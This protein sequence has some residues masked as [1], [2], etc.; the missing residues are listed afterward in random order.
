MTT[1]NTREVHI[2][3]VG[4]GAKAAALAAR[5]SVLRDL[6]HADIRITVF[7]REK[8]GA[9]WTGENGYTDGVQA[10]CTP[11][12]RD[13]GFPYKS[14][15]GPA[16]DQSI[17]SEYSWGR[18][19]LERAGGNRNA[20]KNWVDRGRMP[21]AHREYARY[22]DWA[23]QKSSAKVVRQEV[24]RLDLAPGRKWYVTSAETPRSRPKTY[25]QM[26]DGVVVTGPGPA[27]RV[28]MVDIPPHLASRVFDGQSFWSNL[29]KVKEILRHEKEPEIVVIGGGGTG[30]AILAWLT[31]NGYSDVATKLIANKATLFSRG[32]SVFENNLFGDDEKWG[33][34]SPKNR[35]DFFERLNRGVV[36]NAVMEDL[37]NATNLE[38]IDGRAREITAVSKRRRISELTVRVQAWNPA[39]D[40][41]ARASLVVD[42]SGFDRWWFLPLIEHIPDV[43]KLSSNQREKL[44]SKIQP[45]LTLRWRLPPLHA[46][47]LAAA[48]GPGYGNLMALGAMSDSILKFYIPRVTIEEPA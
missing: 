12:E 35:E 41:S 30:A 2:A 22:L 26:F 16:V 6:G 10:L 27:R 15:R 11:V 13:L 39:L 38:L 5:A 4:G 45:D 40:F 33:A 21:P 47:N 17:Y 20:F 42:A 28:D 3:I 43:A 9:H 31:K 8:I 48:R 14:F 37:K 29:N 23:I 7:E 34:L 18:F 32:D 44:E 1:A 46:P 36:W 25:P 19:N 24:L